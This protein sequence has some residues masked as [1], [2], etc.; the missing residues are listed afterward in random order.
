MPSEDDD[1]FLLAMDIDSVVAQHKLANAQAP[2]GPENQPYTPSTRTEQPQTP[3][4]MVKNSHT[5]QVMP[6]SGG[7]YHDMHNAYIPANSVQRLAGAPAVGA[8]PEDLEKQRRK[9]EK[10]RQIQQLWQELHEDAGAEEAKSLLMGT[11]LPLLAASTEP[12]RVPFNSVAKDI[13]IP[14]RQPGAWAGSNS[15]GSYSIPPS[16]RNHAPNFQQN[17]GN[18]AALSFSFLAEEEEEA[19][20]SRNGFPGHGSSKP[21]GQFHN[22]NNNSNSNGFQQFGGGHHNQGF[23]NGSYGYD[24]DGRFQNQ[25]GGYGSNGQARYNAS[26]TF[27]QYNNNNSGQNGYSNGPVYRPSNY[28]HGYSAGSNTGCGYSAVGSGS[29][30]YGGTGWIGA[31]D[32]GSNP[33]PVKESVPLHLVLEDTGEGRY[34]SHKSEANV[35]VLSMYAISGLETLGR[36]FFLAD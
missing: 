9:E 22:G 6:P 18:S 8:S 26:N 24:D 28:E 20:D 14:G 30:T 21:A 32:V 11:Q 25:N 31:S 2:N 12:S 27:D 7:Y 35:S 4:T 36:F 13:P 33:M 3:A 1:E 34:L 17:G 23:G 19:G 10:V 29:G 5:Q 15:N 16:A